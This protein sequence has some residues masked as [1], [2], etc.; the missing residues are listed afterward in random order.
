MGMAMTF[1]GIG[2][3]LMSADNKAVC[4]AGIVCLMVSVIKLW[5]IDNKRGECITYGKTAYR[6][7]RRHK[8]PVN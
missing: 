7:R 6:A 4:V 3:F 5:R 1:A 2:F 8:K